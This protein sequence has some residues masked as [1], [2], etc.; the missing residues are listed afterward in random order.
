MS[1][2][3]LDFGTDEVFAWRVRL[4]LERALCNITAA[5][6]EIIS[7]VAALAD[8]G[9]CQVTHADIAA[10]KDYHV[11]TVQDALG[12][13]QRLGL[14]SWRKSY[15]TAA[16]GLLRRREA[17]IY[18]REMPPG[19]AMKRPDVRRHNAGARHV[20]RKEVRKEAREVRRGAP[21]RPAVGILPDLAAIAVRREA[22]LGFKWLANRRR[23]SG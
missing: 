2:L 13:A 18:Q 7:H 22:E 23:E 10:A 3:H 21:E 17:N 12:R 11:R 14:L 19:P 4:A 15:R 1:R 6:V 5:H 9:F 8:A 20:A 16:D